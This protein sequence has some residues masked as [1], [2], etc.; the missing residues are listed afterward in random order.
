MTQPPPPATDGAPIC[1]CCRGSGAHG[2]TPSHTMNDPRAD[3]EGCTTCGGS[4][5]SWHLSRLDA[6]AGWRELNGRTTMT[7]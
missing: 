7:W 5:R 1:G 3:W 4:G 6:C 2:W